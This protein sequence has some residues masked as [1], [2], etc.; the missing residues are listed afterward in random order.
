M[1]VAADF[2]LLNSEKNKYSL[3]VRHK[4]EKGAYNGSITNPMSR[5]CSVNVLTKSH[6]NRHSHK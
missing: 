6:I 2:I 3:I 1:Y 5:I 4:K